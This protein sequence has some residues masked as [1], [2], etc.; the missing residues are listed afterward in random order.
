[1]ENTTNTKTSRIDPQQVHNDECTPN[2]LIIAKDDL[3]LPR[4]HL[5]NNRKIGDHFGY[6]AERKSS[7]ADGSSRLLLAKFV[8]PLGRSAGKY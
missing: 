8:V 6:C 3:I 7:R 4:N 1:M 5:S 2:L